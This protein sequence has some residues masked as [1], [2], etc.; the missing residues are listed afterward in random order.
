MS[1]LTHHCDKT[2][3]KCLNSEF[4]IFVTA[5]FSSLANKYF[6]IDSSVVLLSLW[7]YVSATEF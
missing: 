2:A 1:R 7:Y 3:I 4:D 6:R 5:N